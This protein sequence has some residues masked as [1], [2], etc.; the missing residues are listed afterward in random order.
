MKLRLPFARPLPIILV[1]GLTISLSVRAETTASQQRRICSHPLSHATQALTELGHTR[2]LVL[3]ELHFA[4]P[5]VLTQSGG[6]HELRVFAQTTLGGSYNPEPVTIAAP[7]V[8]IGVSAVTYGIAA[9]G[10]HCETQRVSSAVVFALTETL[11]AVGLEK[12][13]FGRVWPTNGRDPYA[14][15]RLEHPEDAW[16]YRPFSRGIDAAFPS[17]HTATMFAAAA[18]LRAANPEWG[19]WGYLGYPFAIAVGLGMW[20]G[21]HHWASDVISGAMLGEALGSATGRAWAKSP[22]PDAISIS[23]LPTRGGALLSLTGDL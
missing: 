20:W 15:D 23:V 19:V 13:V 7:Y 11:L 8:T 21:D 10:G 5:I 4:A 14:P 17:G 22:D 1:L 3:I 6:D 18:A 12:W 16:I 9:L 2:E